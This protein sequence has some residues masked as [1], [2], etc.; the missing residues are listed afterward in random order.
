MKT[1][2]QQSDGRLG[3]DATSTVRSIAVLEPGYADYRQEEAILAGHGVRIAAVGL[4]DDAI[5][6]LSKI[7]PLAILVRERA[8]TAD[9]I[10]ACPDLKLIVRYGV[11]VDNVDIA[12]ATSRQIYVANVPDYGADIEVSEHALALYLAVQRRVPSRDREVREGV[13]GVGQRAV[14]PARENAVLGLIG[15]GRIGIATARK[16]RAIGFEHVVAFD[17]Y[18]KPETAACEA[19]TL[20]ELDELCRISDVVSLHAPL[21]PQT[22]HIL[23]AQRLA[24][25]KPTTILVNV[26]RGGLVDEAALAAALNQR[27]ILGAG[28]DVF[29][30]E[31]VRDDNPL[32]ASPNTV[33]SDHAAWYSERSVR[34]LQAKAAEEV[35]RVIWGDHPANWL[36]KWTL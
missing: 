32:L 3:H 6:T 12:H 14:I 24:L 13:W 34:T 17:P 35:A 1:M 23:D 16:F 26:S 29:E 30:V 21:T 2:S 4:G 25:F 22:R 8:V 18:L 20:V 36:N 9:V 5:P 11:G 27:R 15:C 33:L 7:N 19:I 10:D 31:P 28:I